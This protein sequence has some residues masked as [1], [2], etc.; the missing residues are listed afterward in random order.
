MNKTDK[1][2]QSIFDLEFM[3]SV[4]EN[5]DYDDIEQINKVL[6]DFIEFSAKNV[7]ITS[8]KDDNERFVRLAYD[9]IFEISQL[10]GELKDR[11]DNEVK[12]QMFDVVQMTLMYAKILLKCSLI[13]NGAKA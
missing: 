1:L 3:I 8:M 4:Y 7:K 6:D 9:N 10:L 12:Q 5:T 2:E 13:K 11:S